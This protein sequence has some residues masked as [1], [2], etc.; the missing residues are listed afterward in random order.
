MRAETDTQVFFETHFEE[1]LLC[2]WRK[3]DAL[4]RVSRAVTQ[5]LHWRRSPSCCQVGNGS[6]RV[7]DA[8]APEPRSNHLLSPFFART[9]SFATETLDV[10]HAIDD[11]EVGW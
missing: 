11:S 4:W 5:A 10:C 2:Q 9:K 1:R 6:D 8:L 3:S 7:P